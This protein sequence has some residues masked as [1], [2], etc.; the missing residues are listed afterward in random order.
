MAFTRPCRTRATFSGPKCR[1]EQTD[2]QD[3]YL[4]ALKTAIADPGTRDAWV[5]RVLP[6]FDAATGQAREAYKAFT[7]LAGISVVWEFCC[8][9]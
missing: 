9:S 3:R 1:T 5:A 7:G 4:A 6:V 8:R 2:T